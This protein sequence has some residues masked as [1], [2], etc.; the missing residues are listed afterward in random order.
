ML[1]REVGQPVGGGDGRAGM[2]GEA[3]G[4]A[5]AVL[6]NAV[7]ST[8]QQAGQRVLHPQPGNFVEELQQLHALNQ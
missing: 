5:E 7:V 2:A 1:E 4:I 8:G 6:Q 3:H